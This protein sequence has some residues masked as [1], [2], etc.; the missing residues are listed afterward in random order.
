MKHNKYR[1]TSRKKTPWDKSKLEDLTE[2]EK[3]ISS[4]FKNN[5]NSHH[6]DLK[7]TDE[8]DLLNSFE[9]EVCKICG[10]SNFY[11]NGY[12]SN[13]IRKYKCNDCGK[14]FT[15]TKNTIFENHKISIRE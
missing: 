1:S 4:T 2:L 13:C 11:K 8:A 10:S 9:P 7:E 14:G 3:F 6:P 15:I 12:T 5:Y